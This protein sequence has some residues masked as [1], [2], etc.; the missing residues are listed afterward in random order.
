MCQLTFV[1]ISLLRPS[2]GS[3]QRKGW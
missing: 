3:D 2:G 1:K